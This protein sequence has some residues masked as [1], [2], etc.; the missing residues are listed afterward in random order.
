MSSK[1]HRFEMNN[2]KIVLDINSGSVH[3]VDDLVWDIVSLY[4]DNDIES[5]IDKLKDKYNEDDIKEAYSEIKIL[6]E[7]ELLFSE[8]KYPK[9]FEYNSQNVI[10][11]M[12]LHVAHDCNLKCEY[13]F[14]SQGD[15]QGERLLM[16]LEVG[17]KALEFLVENSGNRR[18][19]EVDFFGGEP[20]M[21]FDVVKELVYYGRE[22]EKKHNKNFR[23]T[24]TTN[25]V[26]LNDE[27]IKFI[28][29]HMDNVVLSLDG[30]KEVNDNMRKTINGGGSHDI[31]VPKFKKLVDERGDKLYYVRGT[32]TSK[33]LDF[34]KDVLYIRDLGFDIV[35][36]EPVVT[37]PKFD[38]AIREEH[39]GIILEEYEKLSK[40]YIRYHKEGKGFQFFHFMTDL[41]QGPCIIKRVAGCGAG[42]E[43]VAVTPEGDLYPCHQFVGEEEFK[44]GDIWN[45]IQNTELRDKFKSANIFTKE[46]CKDCWA[47]FYCSGGCHANAYHNNGDIKK[48]DKIGCE[49]EKKRIEC[50]LSIAANLNQEG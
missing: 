41:N 32:F 12:C 20:L 13:C 30:R 43:Y 6:E 10:K 2:K 42:S 1:I 34:S 29:E 50:A 9:D 47:R 11:A 5:V 16:P 18:N 4:E 22:L 26:L 36:V 31:I 49:M 45:G 44:M 21:N 15:F 7:N 19:L 8:D 25:G 23:F 39:L 48:P 33:N 27:N 46:G 24:I 40:E 28:N 17:K 38:Y 37:D 3:V 14:A 35:S